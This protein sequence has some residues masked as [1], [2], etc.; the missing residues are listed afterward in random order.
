MRDSVNA[1]LLLSCQ[2]Q[3]GIVAAV[4]NFIFSNKGNI[5]HAAQHTS[6][7]DKVFF[8]RVEWELNGFM[9]P[10]EEISPAFVHIAQTFDMS[11]EI[12]FTDVLPKMA[13]FASQHPHCLYDL[14]SRQQMGEIGA[15]LMIIISNHPE[16]EAIAKQFGVEFGYFPIDKQNKAAQEEKEISLLEKLDV[17]FIVLARYM[18]ILSPSFVTRFPNRIIN[19]HHSFLPAFAGGNP[20]QQAYE[21]GVKIIGATSHYVTEKLDDGPIIAQDVIRISHRDE[22]KDMILKGK[23]LER[24]VLARAVQMHLQNRILIYGQ[25]TIIFE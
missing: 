2:D 17:D 14:L 7:M 15:E 11:W 13:I 22:V 1:I 3:R 8:M 9:I 23:D 21:R 20:Y 5:I 25:R 16:N 18:Q 10:R 6:E 4:S 12:R 19:I 24:V